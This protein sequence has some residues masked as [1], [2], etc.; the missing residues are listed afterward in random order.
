MGNSSFS[1]Q[2]I[3]SLVNQ[4]ARYRSSVKRKKN[5]LVIR[6]NTKER[7]WELLEI[8]RTVHTDDDLLANSSVYGALHSLASFSLFLSFS[9]CA[10]SI[11]VFLAPAR[12]FTLCFFIHVLHKRDR[13]KASLRSTD[14]GEKGTGA[15]ER[16][17]REKEREW[18][19]GGETLEK[20]RGL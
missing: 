6:R 5:F 2:E 13:D 9:L 1:R 8:R 17:T 11:R 4:G 3:D 19:D 20:G 15:T 14:A 12:S 16:E 18:R 10:S 7:S